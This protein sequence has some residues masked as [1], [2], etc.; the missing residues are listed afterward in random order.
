MTFSC[1]TY[2][3]VKP[4]LLCFH[5]FLLSPPNKYERGKSTVQYSGERKGRKERTNVGKKRHRKSVKDR[6]DGIWPFDVEANAVAAN[7][8]DPPRHLII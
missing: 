1:K 8:S 4:C 3:Q 5:C 2:D 6:K 7:A